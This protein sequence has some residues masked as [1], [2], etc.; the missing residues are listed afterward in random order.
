MLEKKI[1]VLF[2]LI[3]TYLGAQTDKSLEYYNAANLATSNK[4]YELADSLYTLSLSLVPNL[5]TYYNRAIV[6]KK[7]NKM[8]DYCSDIGNASFLGDRESTDLFFKDCCSKD[9]I[10]Y[11]HEG[12]VVNKGQHIYYEVICQMKYSSDNTFRKYNAANKKLVSYE[13]KNGDTMFVLSPTPPIYPEDEEYIKMILANNSVLKK[14][15]IKDLKYGYGWAVVTFT[16]L[17]NGENAN[18]K[19]KSILG[20]EYDEKVEAIFKKYIKKWKPA[21]Y[22]GQKVNY[23][24]SVPFKPIVEK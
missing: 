2:M 1:T 15:D 20:K 17:K 11:N 12:V 18:I 10:Y 16:V 3:C 21:E 13:V 9:T 8:S 24:M 6:R 22:N 5:D 7:M 4:Q 23:S 19:C 14:D